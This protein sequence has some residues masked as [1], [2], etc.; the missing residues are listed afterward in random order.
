MVTIC[1]FAACLYDL[2]CRLFEKHLYRLMCSLE[3]S[4]NKSMDSDS[5]CC[6]HNSIWLGW[7]LDKYFSRIKLA[8]Q[9]ASQISKGIETA[10]LDFRQTYWL[11]QFYQMVYVN[12]PRPLH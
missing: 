10:G 4:V 5:C 11:Q 2:N 6:T 3:Y 8:H 1:S 7:T 9:L 12:G